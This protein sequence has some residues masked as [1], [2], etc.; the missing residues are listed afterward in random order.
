HQLRAL[1]D[2]ARA[3]QDKTSRGGLRVSAHQAG[4]WRELTDLG[5]TYVQSQRW[6]AAVD[7]LLALDSLPAPATPGSLTAELRP[8][9]RDGFRWLDFLWAHGLGGV[10]ADDMGL[11]KTV[12]MLAAIC[13]AKEQDRLA[14]PALVVAPTSVVGNW[15]A[16][17]T[18]FAP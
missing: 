9:Q 3:L 1:I 8:Y 13:R 2:E 18:R 14:S 10:L 4:L 7:G 6:S 15:L 11:G 5:P 12:Q 16:E 17:V